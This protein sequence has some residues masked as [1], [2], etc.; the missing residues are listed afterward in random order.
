MGAYNNIMHTTNGQDTA[1]DVCPELTVSELYDL[2]V[3]V[4]IK[5]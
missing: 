3:K 1:T 5:A 4:V 2:Q